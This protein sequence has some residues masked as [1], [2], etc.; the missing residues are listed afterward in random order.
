VVID[1]IEVVTPPARAPDPDPLASLADRRRGAS[2]H[3]QGG[4]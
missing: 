2:R 3:V 4:R 1:R